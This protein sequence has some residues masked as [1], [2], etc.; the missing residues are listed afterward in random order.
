MARAQAS[1]KA[2]GR[3]S[4]PQDQP[5]ASKK[6]KASPE[7]TASPAI[8]TTQQTRKK[9]CVQPHKTPI[10]SPTR[11]I[12]RTL[13]GLELARL[14]P[15]PAGRRAARSTA[16]PISFEDTPPTSPCPSNE[17]EASHTL[18][19][20]LQDFV[21]LNSAMLA[22]LSLHYA[23]HGTASPL[24]LKHLAPSVTRIWGK[25]RVTDFDLKLCLGLL[26]GNKVTPFR[27]FDYGQGKICLELEEEHGLKRVGARFN[28]DS[29]SNGFELK[30][31]EL[32]TRACKSD[33]PAM[34]HAF[35]NSLSQATV[36]LSPNATKTAQSIALK[37]GQKRLLEV[38]GPRDDNDR[39]PTKRTRI[40]TEKSKQPQPALAV[41][42][43]LT[44]SAMTSVVTP[45]ATS[46]QSRAQSL[47]DRICAKQSHAASLPA[48]PTKDQLNRI[49]AL[50]RVEEVMSMLDLL[51][52]AK[53]QGP[54][55]SFP[56]SSLVQNIQG[57]LRSPMAKEEV[58]RCLTV[59]ENEVA[60]GYVKCLKMGSVSGV[61]VN[62]AAKPRR[63]A[64]LASLKAA[65]V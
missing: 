54:R 51:V 27:L 61:V 37:R 1:I 26:E 6:R 22:A 48:R 36:T 56:L 14:S 62:T 28:Q 39:L 9:L 41:A 31:Q 7:P 60:L 20:E 21:A 63:D 23:H 11:A 18:P 15:T 45:P 12:G 50:Q 19:I 8:I 16:S 55:A 33:K 2:F 59:M 52:A 24:D 58:E 49:A 44:P 40:Q 38:L 5:A 30:L 32:W 3:I 46:A 4:K 47:F 43:T 10:D 13:A 64:L 53:G 57:S 17:T 65:G 25:R 35:I 29:L 34:P 42:P